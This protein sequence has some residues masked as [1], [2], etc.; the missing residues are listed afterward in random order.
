MST[1]LYESYWRTMA[2]RKMTPEERVFDSYYDRLV[3]FP[4]DKSRVVAVEFQSFDPEL[5]AKVPNALAEAYI[6]GDL[7]ARMAMTQK[8]RFRPTGRRFSSPRRAMATSSF[9]T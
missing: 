4:V 6:E 1:G 8:A 3:V 5:A 7:E 2:K 9:T